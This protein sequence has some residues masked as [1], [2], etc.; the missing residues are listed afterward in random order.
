MRH[1]RQPSGGRTPP[2]DSSTN[3][4]TKRI[5]IIAV[6]RYSE[7]VIKTY[8]M[9]IRFWL[10]LWIALFATNS[11]AAAIQF[12]VTPLGGTAFRYTYSLSG[13]NFLVNQN[14]NQDLDIQF[15][16]A[17][18]GTLS[19]GVVGP[20]FSALLL[21]P[22]NPPGT[23]GDYIAL[24]QVNNPSLA[25]P[26]SVDFLFKGMGTPGGAQPFRV[27]EF[28]K[29]GNFL[30]TVPGNSGLTTPFGT[31]VPEPGSFSLGV[32]ALFI[33]GAWWTVRR[34]LPVRQR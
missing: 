11:Y 23:S 18:Y 28:D 20:G 1:P 6:V 33:G 3:R 17:L 34:R 21:Q 2:T 31:T 8:I 30:R 10:P 26:F 27:D 22:N 25:G 12:K 5:R 9:R 29:N 19:N 32:V 16:P 4:S 7:L 15:D 14:V 13:F 24:A